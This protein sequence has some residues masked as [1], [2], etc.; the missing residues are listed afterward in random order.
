MLRYFRN[1]TPG[2]LILWCYFIWYLVV[3]VR[4]FSPDVHVWLTAAGISGIIGTALLINTTRSG[5]QR[6]QLEFWPAARLF[7]FP[8]CV[9]SFSSLVKGKGFILVFSPH[10]MEMIVALLLCGGLWVAALVARRPAAETLS[11]PLG[12]NDDARSR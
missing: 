10:G 2:R 4:Y 8:F 7:L 1:L 6:V 11:S 5:S 9:S 12:A 3:A